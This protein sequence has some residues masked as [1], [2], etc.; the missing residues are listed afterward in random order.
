MHVM[1]EAGSPIIAP[2][3]TSNRAQKVMALDLMSDI[4]QKHRTSTAEK[5]ELRPWISKGFTHLERAELPIRPSILHLWTY[6]L[7]S[8]TLCDLTHIRS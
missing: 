7:H 1:A 3:L 5:A 4:G 8:A 6:Q 2:R